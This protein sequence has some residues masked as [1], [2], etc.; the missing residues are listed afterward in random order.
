MPQS[1]P[2]GLTKDHILNALADLDAEIDHPFGQPTGYELV[3]EGKRYAPKAVTHGRP[4][5]L[6]HCGDHMRG[7]QAEPMTASTY[8]T[9]HIPDNRRFI[10][11]RLE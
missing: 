7:G 11:R 4:R 5:F 1:I 3:H 2:A 9:H 6:R 8:A 10:R